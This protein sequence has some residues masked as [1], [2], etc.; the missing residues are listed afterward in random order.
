MSWL[1]KK[2]NLILILVVI[3]LVYYPWF[4][5]N[6]TLASGDW[7]YLFKETIQG[8]SFFP[9]PS[10]LWLGPYYQITSKFFVEYL[11]ISWEITERVF[12]FWMFLGISFFSSRYL[13]KIIL[14][15][16]KFNLL[17][18]LIFLT[19]SYI[20]MVV[21]GGQMGVALGYSLS[22]MVFGKFILLLQRFSFPNLVSSSLI[23]ALQVMFDPRIAYI[24][25]IGL[26]LFAIFSLIFSEKKHSII[27]SVLA[28]FFISSIVVFILNYYWILS[29]VS[30]DLSGSTVNALKYLSF[31]SFSQSISLLHPNWPENIFGKIYFMRP[32]FIVLPVF[33]YFSLFF[34]NIRK[35]N[36]EILFFA[37]LGIIGAF[38]SKGVSEPFGVLYQWAFSNIPL[39][40]L[41]RDPTKFYILVV[42][43]YSILIPFALE[44]IG[45]RFPNLSWVIFIV[46][47]LVLISPAFSGKLSGTFKPNFVPS[48]YSEFKNFLNNDTKYSNVLWMPTHSPFSFF[49]NT[50]PILGASYLGDMLFAE[51]SDFQKL[52]KIMNDNNVGYVVIPQ[53]SEGRIFMT[54]R[55]YD[56]RQYFKALEKM[57]K[58]PFLT[59]VRTFGKIVVFK[60]SK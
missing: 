42:L 39:F 3:L 38:L 40:F 57:K 49:S 52:K 6:R 35:L 17:T 43:S 12:W 50:H 51:K 27:K 45:G 29:G 54:D 15:N 26:A 33:A 46:F 37:F 31:G 60:V 36:K 14:R 25:G 1:K 8:F 48:E 20:L 21:G 2:T 30:K 41:F 44:K 13:S 19:N 58:I 28:Y 18:T 53:D 10:F 34:L 4:L 59:S 9:D 11:N 5:I 16:S 47:W 32:E 7:P 24:T 56:E 22:P 23:L 55:I